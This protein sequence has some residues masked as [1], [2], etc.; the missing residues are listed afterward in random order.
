MTLNILFVTDEFRLAEG[1]RK[2]GHLV[3]VTE[4]AHRGMEMIVDHPPFDV[5][6]VERQTDIYLALNGI[7]LV[8]R[9]YQRHN[10]KMP[11]VLIMCSHSP[12]ELH[13]D[14]VRF[15]GIKTQQKWPS[16]DDFCTQ[17][18]TWYTEATP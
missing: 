16:A 6:I 12:M 7:G 3:T 11:K 13:E 15:E 5:I 10:E 1:L 17:I 2:H 4:F 14:E 9:L 8:N 18:E